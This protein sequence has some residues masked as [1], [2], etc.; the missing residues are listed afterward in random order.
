MRS[1]EFGVKRFWFHII[2]IHVRDAAKC[3]NPMPFGRVLLLES[4]FELWA[5]LWGSSPC[6][7]R[8]FCFNCNHKGHF[9]IVWSNGLCCF[10][11]PC[12]WGWC[13][14]VH[15]EQASLFWGIVCNSLKLM[16]GSSRRSKKINRV[17]SCTWCSVGLDCESQ[18]NLCL[19]KSFFYTPIVKTFVF[20]SRICMTKSKVDWEFNLAWSTETSS[21]ITRSFSSDGHH[22]GVTQWSFLPI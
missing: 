20:G 16:F 7:E 14:I 4:I 15:L 12:W 21:W 6:H 2:L 11:I 17:T 22:L 1:H 18:V 10:A 19:S 5:W 9:M 8:S 13:M 3:H